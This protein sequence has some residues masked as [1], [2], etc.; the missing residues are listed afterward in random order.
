[1][2]L[3]KPK[4]S[5]PEA[6][7]EQEEKSDYRVNGYK[8]STGVIDNDDNDPRQDP[9]H[10]TTAAKLDTNRNTAKPSK[11]QP[12]EQAPKLISLPLRCRLLPPRIMAARIPKGIALDSRQINRLRHADMMPPVTKETLSE[13]D[14]ERIMQNVYL[15]MDANFEPELHFLPDLGGEKG[16]QKRI[17]ADDY[18]EALSIEIMIYTYAN[19]NRSQAG[20]IEIVHVPDLVAMAKDDNLF[21]PRLPVMF[22][23]LHG[24]LMTLVPDRD[25]ASVSQN[26][27]ISHLM[28]QVHKGVLDLVS[29]SKWLAD[30]LKTHCAPMRD[31]LADEMAAEIGSG[32][33]HADA[34]KVISGLRKLFKILELMKLVSI[35]SPF[36]FPLPFLDILTNVARTLPIT[37]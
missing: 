11:L 29:L 32:S 33:T 27:D 22:E 36:V 20:E 9:E 17:M 18:W 14:L 1:M 30:L 34:A 6:R 8:P 16:R 26:L 19:M 3:Q 15:R 25:H 21:Q 35:L 4:K 5:R 31:Q 2:D 37:N 24:I 23:T 7:N 12:L 13:L 28:Q 10:E